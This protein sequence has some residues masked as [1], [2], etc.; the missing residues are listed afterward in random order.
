MDPAEYLA[1]I[2]LLFYGI[3]LAEL[4]G[5]WRRFMDP[6]YFYGPY[7]L[8]TLMF[9]EVAIWNVYLYLDVVA[10]LEG[11]S[12]YRYWL[13]LAQPM[14]F[15]LIVSALTPE[16]ENRDTAGYFKKRMPIVF[17]LM[18]VFITIHLVPSFTQ[19]PP[20]NIPRIAAILF[21]VVIAVTG[22]PSLV[23]VLAVIWVASLFMRG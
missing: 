13:Y 22:R 10:A 4:L 5:Q 18:A 14:V 11:I 6:G 1:F 12:Y 16:A 21:C 19:A 7:V 8:T 23:Y 3:A 20:V 9:T 15:L 17:G 2:P